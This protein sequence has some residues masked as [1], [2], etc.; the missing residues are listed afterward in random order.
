M[1]FLGIILVILMF[2]CSHSVN[3]ERDAELKKACGGPVSRL[4]GSSLIKIEEDWC[5]IKYRDRCFMVHDGYHELVVFE[6][7]CQS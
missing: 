7:T 2:G 4:K 5:E 1:K 3:S 6:V